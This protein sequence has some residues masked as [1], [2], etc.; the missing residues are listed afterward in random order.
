MCMSKDRERVRGRERILRGLRDEHGAQPGT[1][2]HYPETMTPAE[3]KSPV[4]NLL[5]HPSATQQFTFLLYLSEMLWLLVLHFFSPMCFQSLLQ[6][7]IHLLYRH[8]HIW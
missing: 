8:S 3:I 2:S 4:P 7:S 1:R 5:S 6:L